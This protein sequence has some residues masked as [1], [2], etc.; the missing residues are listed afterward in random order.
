MSSGLSFTEEIVWIIPPKTITTSD[1]G[2][3]SIATGRYGFSKERIKW[4]ARKEVENIPKKQINK[5][6]PIFCR[7]PFKTKRNRKEK[8][9]NKG[10]G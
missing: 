1:F 10:S 6:K 2:K 9:K 8:M 7:N 4:F 3:D 5:K